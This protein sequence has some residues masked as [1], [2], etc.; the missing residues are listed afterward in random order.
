MKVE[1]RKW[2]DRSRLESVKLDRD[3][4][5]PVI[6]EI[7][8][9][10]M[11]LNQYAMLHCTLVRF[12]SSVDPSLSK[13]S[14]AMII[15]LTLTLTGSP[16]LRIESTPTLVDPTSIGDFLDF[17]VSITRSATESQLVPVSPVTNV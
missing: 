7:K 1:A 3:M 6:E 16:N 2:N 5:V 17:S 10:E 12:V 9:V 4:R 15:S 11:L 13:T 14:S 8:F